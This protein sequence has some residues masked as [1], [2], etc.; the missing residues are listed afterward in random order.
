MAA[1]ATAQNLVV[2]HLQDGFPSGRA[3][4]SVAHVGAG[5]M[6]RRFTDRQRRHGTAAAMATDTRSDDLT[7][8][9]GDHRNP[10]TGAVARLANVGG[11]VVIGRF[12]HGRGAVVATQ[13][14]AENARVI[15]P[16]GRPRRGVVAYLARLIGRNVIAGFAR[17][18]HAVVAGIAVAR[19]ARVVE[20]C[21]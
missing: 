2:I 11:A 4:A 1:A 21:R 20:S 14:I 17:S 16:R 7:V 13:A 8:I 3:M 10:R 12:A 18:L 15:E 6:S 9:N 5:N 19:N